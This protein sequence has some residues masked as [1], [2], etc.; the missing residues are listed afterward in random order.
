MKS[1]N[2]NAVSKQAFKPI[3]AILIVNDAAYNWKTSLQLIV[4]ILVTN[5]DPRTKIN[6][7]KKHLPVFVLNKEYFSFKTAVE[8]PRFSNG[9]FLECLEILYR[10]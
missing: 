2:E 3:E 10:V 4:D 5:G 1:S 7:S 8:R 9:A 6:N